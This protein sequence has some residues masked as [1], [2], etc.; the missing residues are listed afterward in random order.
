MLLVNYFIERCLLKN[1]HCRNLGLTSIHMATAFQSSDA[2]FENW[3]KCFIALRYLRDGLQSFVDTEIESQ[4]RNIVNTLK[5]RF[6]TSLV[7]CKPCNVQPGKF[8]THLTKIDCSTCRLPHCASTLQKHQGPCSWQE[9]LQ[10]NDKFCK[11]CKLSSHEM[12]VCACTAETILPKH[13][14]RTCTYPKCN[15]KKRNARNKMACTNNWCSHF[16]DEILKLHEFRDPNFVNSTPSLW[17]D[18]PWEFAK[19]FLNCGGYLASQS[20]DD[21]DAA[22]LI[23]ICRSNTILKTLI[24]N[25]SELETVNYLHI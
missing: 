21:V 20:S 11:Y 6:E 5:S 17:K 24:K 19:C 2:G 23:S 1:V 9:C 25:V 3:V 12:R 16:Y 15:C 8:C 10:C 13:D 7:H 4:H 22:G 18:S 14:R